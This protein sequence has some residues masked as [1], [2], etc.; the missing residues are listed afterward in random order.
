MPAIHKKS[1]ASGGP[2]QAGQ[3][4]GVGQALAA[5]A[6]QDSATAKT[7]EEAARSEE[8]ATEVP[9]DE[10][11]EAP[12]ATGLTSSR[13]L[14]IGYTF[15]PSLPADLAPCSIRAVTRFGTAQEEQGP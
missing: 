13:Q 9:A 5:A 1:K 2:G 6:R 4:L 10:P 8:E 3:A 14:I 11:A 7:T 12:A 15:A